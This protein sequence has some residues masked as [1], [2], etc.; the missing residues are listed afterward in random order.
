MTGKDQLK[1]TKGDNM[2]MQEQLTAIWNS[3]GVQCAH[4]LTKWIESQEGKLIPLPGARR[5]PSWDKTLLKRA[6]KNLPNWYLWRN[7]QY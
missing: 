7:Q 3:P 1:T 4:N 5:K 6:K 2:T